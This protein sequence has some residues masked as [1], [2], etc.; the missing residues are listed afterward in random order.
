[1]SDNKATVRIYVPDP[2]C[3]HWLIAQLEAALKENAELVGILHKI[4]TKA[5]NTEDKN[6]NRIFHIVN[7][8]LEKYRMESK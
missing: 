6:L 8:Y 5:K 1:M 3:Y 2:S 4:R 7:G